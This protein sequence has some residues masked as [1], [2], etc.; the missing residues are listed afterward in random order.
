MTVLPAQN[1]SP[2]PQ[3]SLGHLWYLSPWLHGD[4]KYAMAKQI[5]RLQQRRLCEHDGRD[6]SETWITSNWMK[7][8]KV[9]PCPAVYIARLMFCSCVWD[10]LLNHVSQGVLV[11]SSQK[12]D[13]CHH[14]QMSWKWWHSC[15]HRQ[16]CEQA[17]NGFK[18]F[19]MK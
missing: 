10:V 3:L 7:G 9:A 13:A 15:D 19:A 2:L 8:L 6:G 4:N 12:S 14:I 16:S 5:P 11:A 18:E 17:S 1:A